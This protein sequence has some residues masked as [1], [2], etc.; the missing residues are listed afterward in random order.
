MNTRTLTKHSL[1]LA[2]TLGL[3]APALAGNG[4]GGSAGMGNGSQGQAGTPD[5]TQTRQQL[6]DGSCL[7]EGAAT[8]TRTRQGTGTMT[9]DRLRLRDGSALPAPAPQQ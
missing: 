6:R 3:A 1:I 7:L 9:R 2:I 5:M 4:R 8:Q